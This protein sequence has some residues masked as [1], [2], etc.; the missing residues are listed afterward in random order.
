MFPSINQQMRHGS[1]SQDDF[2]WYCAR[3]KL[4]QEHIAAGW[5]RSNLGLSVFH[6]R[7]VLE[8]KTKRGLVK[9]NEPLFPSYLFVQF[10]LSENLS[11]VQYAY[12]VSTVLRFNSQI[13]RIPDEIIDELQAGFPGDEPFFVETKIN[14]GSEIVIS[15]GAFMGMK[16]IVLRDIP[17]RQRV[18]VLLEM[19]G[20]LTQVE[21]DRS[22]I[23]ID[24]SERVLSIPHLAATDRVVLPV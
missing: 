4:K 24:K 6:P 8:R 2:G 20:R 13:P 14:A 1:Y 21:I 9:V 15:D 18:Q 23:T 19:I 22:S 10:K 7:I 17:S 5:L 12:G 11:D 16:A 3:T